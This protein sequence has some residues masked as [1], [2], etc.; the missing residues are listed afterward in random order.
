MAGGSEASIRHGDAIGSARVDFGDAGMVRGLSA[1]VGLVDEAGD[2][3]SEQ[4][5]EVQA[6]LEAIE[7][8]PYRVGHRRARGDRD[9]F[10]VEGSSEA[11]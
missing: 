7:R 9:A 1:A 3:L 5:G 2:V 4:L 6:V 11:N 10:V 8:D